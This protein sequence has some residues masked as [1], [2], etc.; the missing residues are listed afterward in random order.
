[1]EWIEVIQGA[2]NYIEDHLLEDI[3]AD[4]VAKQVYTSSAYFQKIFRIITGI[5]FGEYVRSRRLSLA[6]EEIARGSMKIIDIASKYGYETPE[7]FTKAFVR[8]HD[9][10]PSAVRKSTSR[11]RYFSPLRIQIN[12]EGGTIM[13]RR[14]IPNVEKLYDTKT[15]NYMFPSC[16]RSLMASLNE[17]EGYDFSFFAGVTGDLFNMTWLEPK[18]RYNDSY[19]NVCKDSQIPIRRA[20]D[21]CGYAYSYHAHEEIITHKKEFT[22]RIMDSIDRGIP[23]LTFGIVGPPVCS[24]ISGYA[25][26]GDILIGWS[27]FT[28]ETQDDEIFDHVFSSNYFQVKNDLHQSE[29][30]IFIGPKKANPSIAESIRKSL[31]NLIEIKKLEST[32][33]IILG[34]RAFQAWADSLRCD[35]LF[36][37]EAMLEGALDT[38]RSCAVQV[39]TNLFYMDDYLKRAMTLCPDLKNFI[40]H[41]AELFMKEKMAFDKVIEFQGGYF[42]EKDRHALLDKDFRNTL[43][44]YVKAV[45]ARYEDVIS[46]VSSYP[47]IS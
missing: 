10:T 2:I 31:K 30:L 32:D 17:D 29:A 11:M 42:F 25:Q 14:L 40:S 22:K 46:F 21:A 28:G 26:D 37:D 45:G 4:E 36:Q 19:S 24:I 6:A 5:T 8:F 34:G 23:V 9:M 1:M 16:M 7:S 3:N 27:Q 33:E 44:E 47:M 18:W 41:L 43:A 20:F 39:G 35:E 12:I 38:Y 13:S 15:E